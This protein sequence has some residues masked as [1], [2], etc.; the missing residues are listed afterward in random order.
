M[1]AIDLLDVRALAE[2]DNLQVAAKAVIEGMRA[3]AHRSRLQ[4]HSVDFADHRPYVAGDDIRHL[5]W[6]VLGRS[7]RLVL[8]RYE[9]EV[10]LGCT[11]VMDGSGSMAYQGDRAAMSKYRYG[12]VLAATLGYLVLEQQ[13]RIGL[14]IFTDDAVIERRPGGRDQFERL[15][16]DLE[17]HKPELGTAPMKALERLAPM[18]VPKGLVVVISDG[19]TAPEVLVEAI[20]RVRHRGHDAALMWVLDPDELDLNLGSVTRFQDLEGEAE[21]VAEPRALREAYQAEVEAHRVALHKA[22]LAREVTFIQCHTDEPP[23][24]PLNRLLVALTHGSA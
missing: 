11:V 8:K 4:G 17:T 22:C 20:E 19:M 9:A 3:G 18:S 1:A 7:D 13:D 12:A 5:D 2:L 14:L 24:V 6:K 23:H 16:H 10:D 21:L 15:C